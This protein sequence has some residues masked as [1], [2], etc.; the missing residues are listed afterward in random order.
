VERRLAETGSQPSGL[1]Y[2][3]VVRNG[4]VSETAVENGNEVGLSIKLA[5]SHA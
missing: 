1:R 5:I 4:S 2:D 3:M